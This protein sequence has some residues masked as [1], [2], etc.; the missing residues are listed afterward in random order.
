MKPN[1]SCH[2]VYKS[3]NRHILDPLRTAKWLCVNLVYHEIKITLRFS[4]PEATRLSVYSEPSAST[5]NP[6]ATFA[7]FVTRLVLHR[8]GKKGYFMTIVDPSASD[9]I[10]IDLRPPCLWMS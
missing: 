6:I 3:N 1:L 4:P 8:A 7:N 2:L 5:N 10:G 9:S